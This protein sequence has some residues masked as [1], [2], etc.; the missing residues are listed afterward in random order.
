MTKRTFLGRAGAAIGVPP[1]GCARAE[2]ERSPETDDVPR[3]VT[4]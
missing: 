1:T 2:A 4:I 3:R